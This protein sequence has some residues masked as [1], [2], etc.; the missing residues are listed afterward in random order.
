MFGL[1]GEQTAQLEQYKMAMRIINTWDVARTPVI[2][3]AIICLLFSVFL[4]AR[5]KGGRFFFLILA[6]ILGL[7]TI[8]MDKFKLYV[9]ERKQ[10]AVKEAVKEAITSM[11]K[12]I[13]E[14]PENVGK[15]AT[16]LLK[17]ILPFGGK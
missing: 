3:A 12:K 6:V 7:G 13:V 11:P 9:Q 16:G 17:K 5:K 4:F 2:I 8:G 1:S 15:G 14:L 10:T